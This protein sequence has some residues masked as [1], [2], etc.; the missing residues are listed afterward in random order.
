MK[1]TMF[2]T[3]YNACS[4]VTDFGDA[5][6]ESFPRSQFSIASTL[7]NDASERHEGFA[8]NKLLAKSCEHT[9]KRDLTLSSKT[10]PVF[11][12][13]VTPGLQSVAELV[14]LLLETNCACIL[15]ACRLWRLP[16][17]LDS[18]ALCL[19][20]HTC[21]SCFVPKCWVGFLSLVRIMSFLECMRAVMTSLADFS[22]RLPG[23]YE[24]EVDVEHGL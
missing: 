7:Q 4:G 16:V 10:H 9:R 20:K 18:Q 14:C 17:R 3:A 22:Y 1:I 6:A 12:R 24:F 13:G 15:G 23:P 19:R 21:T 2:L 8:Q 5:L 11:S